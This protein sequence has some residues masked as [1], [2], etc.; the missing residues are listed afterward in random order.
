MFKRYGLLSK[1]THRVAENQ[2]GLRIDT[3]SEQTIHKV[4]IIT[5]L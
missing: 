1:T 4:G 2:R 3:L 5:E